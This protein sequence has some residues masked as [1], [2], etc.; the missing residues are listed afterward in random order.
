MKFI[1]D[2]TVNGVSA[3]YIIQRDQ[4]A[5]QVP[6]NCFAGE[7][8]SIADAILIRSSTASDTVVIESSSKRG[9]HRR[10]RTIIVSL[11]I[12]MLQREGRWIT[13]IPANPPEEFTISIISLG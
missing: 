12:M 13:H 8:Q 11:I 5:P 2:C 3:K 4:H 1:K 7:S 6:A 9:P 10:H